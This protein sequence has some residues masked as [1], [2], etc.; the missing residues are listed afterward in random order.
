MKKIAATLAGFFILSATIF[1]QQLSAQVKKALLIGIDT[2][3]P[4]KGAKVSPESGRI[5]WPDLSGCKNDALAIKDIIT[6]KFN[7][8]SKDITELYNASATRDAILKGMEDLLNNTPENGLALIYYAGHG[9][10]ITNSKTAEGDGYD[11]SMV[12]ADTWKKG[13]PDIRDKEIARMFNRFIDKKIKLTAIFDCCHSGSI[14]RGIVP[15]PGKSRYIA[16]SDYDVADPIVVTPPETRP[17]SNYLIISAAQDN[18][19][20]KE[21]R[22]DNKQPAHGAFTLAL[23]EVLKQQSPKTSVQALFNSVRAM[24]KAFGKTQEPVLAGDPNR[25]NETLLGIEKG[26]LSDKMYFP[27]LDVQGTKVILQA[28]Y[29]A[30]INPENELTGKND[31]TVVLKVTKVSGLAQSEAVV[32]KGDIANVKKAGPFEVSNWVSSQVPLLKIYVPEGNYTYDDVV[33]QAAVNS[34]L[35]KNTGLKWFNDF[36]AHEP[37]VTINFM[38]G[39]VIGND[40][41]TPNLNTTLKDFSANEVQKFAGNKNLFV[42]LAAPKKLVDAIRA[43][44]T[45]YKTIQL[46]TSPAEAQYILYGTIN[47]NNTIAYGLVKAN[48]SLKDSL[49]SMPLNTRA[50]PMAGNTDAAYKAIIDSL[51]EVSLK[52]SKIRGWLTLTPPQDA[53]FFPY[54]LVMRNS[55]TKKEVDSNGV[56]VGE[57]LDLSIEANEDYLDRPI[58]KKYLYVFTIDINGKMQL[59]YP[60][61]A[62]GSVQNKFPLNTEEGTPRK[63]MNF[64]DRPATASEP[65]GTDNY[66]LIASKEPIQE[67][68]RLFNQ[69]GVRGASRGNNK[70]LS[71]LLDMGNESK[72]RGLNT[73]TPTNW[74]LLR[75]AVKTTH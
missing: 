1:A 40:F 73:A 39:K 29:A 54:R 51:F 22:L 45:E 26:L 19:P 28:G 48:I 31:S 74:N 38:G 72:A 55:V 3:S 50:F 18:E 32:I 70:A 21:H 10:F 62:E 75:L 44:F 7:F 33:K 69:E 4:P 34:D 35:R 64:F 56:K 68:G 14:A 30:G 20:A 60:N 43:K 12:P 61:V 25:F 66:F 71:A 59:I 63:K 57:K 65:V 42:N 16:G 6:S 2:Y 8:N 13:V 5:E 49:E 58:E 17:N 15:D 53:G 46:V 67:P 11:E 36:K 37:D 23:M 52:L 41:V 27:V 47:N 24:I 9:S